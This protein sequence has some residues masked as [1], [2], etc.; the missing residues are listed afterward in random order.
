MAPVAGQP[1]MYYIFKY[2]ERQKIDH[3]ILSVGYKYEA[4][5]NWEKENHW[6]FQISYAIEQEPL[7][8]GGA[9][10][11]A[12]E[13]AKEE[14]VFILNGDTFF[15]VDLNQMYLDHNKANADLTIALK[16]MTRFE[17]YGNVQIDGQNRI[18]SFMEKQY[19]EQGQIN[20]GTYL[21]NRKGH[22]MDNL[23]AKFSFE[24][25]VMQQRFADSY[26]HG[27][28]CDEY[29]ID[30]GIPEDFAKANVEFE[31]LFV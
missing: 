18:V 13:Q 28:L 15:D 7:G 17:R 9:I 16:P 23:G 1:F 19:C 31:T 30:I 10:K 27:A 29:F 5:E 6:P 20:G 12:L 22:L 25:D 14:Q 26:F 24:T 8:T 3:V 11:L 4:I 2:L 21:I